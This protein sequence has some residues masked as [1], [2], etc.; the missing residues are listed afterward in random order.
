LIRIKVFSAD[1]KFVRSIGKYGRTSG[2][3][4]GLCDVTTDDLN[5]IYVCDSGNHCV[6]KYAEN[7][8]YI[9]QWGKSGALNGEFK[10]PACITVHLDRLIVSD[11][12]TNIYIYIFHESL[13]ENSSIQF[14][15]L[16]YFNLVLYRL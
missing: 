16:F 3:F 9:T 4:S 10:C 12:G 8:D 13:Q 14:L 1:F 5:N 15:L 2:C 6:L 7:G 11:W